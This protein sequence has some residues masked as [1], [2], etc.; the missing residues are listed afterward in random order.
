MSL[1]YD[2]EKWII[3]SLASITISLTVGLVLIAHG[4]T[5]DNE[6]NASTTVNTTDFSIDIPDNWVYEVVLISKVKL[7]PNEFGDVLIINEDKW[8]EQVN[9]TGV[10]A[11][12]SQDFLFPIENAGLDLYVKYEIEQRTGINVTSKQNTTIDNETAVRI[13]GDGIDSL[14]GIKFVEYMLMHDKQ[15]YYIAY[16]ANVKDFEKYL[17]QFEQIVKSFKFKNEP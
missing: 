11:S 2:F 16:M 5:V 3:V 6:T 7:A 1:C 13:Y 4:Q 9:N 8:S 10:V 15:P 14:S 12:F 17:P